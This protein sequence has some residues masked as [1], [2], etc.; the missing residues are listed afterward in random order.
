M[1]SLAGCVRVSTK[2]GTVLTLC[3]RRRCTGLAMD[4]GLCLGCQTRAGRNRNQS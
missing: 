4:G 3:P 1:S 2:R